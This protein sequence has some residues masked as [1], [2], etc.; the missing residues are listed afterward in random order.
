MRT[1]P[2]EQL[3][4]AVRWN[5]PVGLHRK[6]F[7]PSWASSHSSQPQTLHKGLGNTPTS[8]TEP[9]VTPSTAQDQ[10]WAN[11]RGKAGL[12]CDH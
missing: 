3:F 8:P 11:L 6:P 12:T 1:R 10:P 5:N 2:A 4:Q 9:E 7:T